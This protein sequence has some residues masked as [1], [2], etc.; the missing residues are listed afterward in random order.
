[1]KVTRL[2]GWADLRSR[3]I[4][5]SRAY[6]LRLEKAEKFPQRVR[7]GPNS[8]AWREDEIERWLQERSSART[9]PPTR[10]ASEAQIELKAS[11]GGAA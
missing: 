9:G 5:F 4:R 6:L 7:L 2:L 10:W 11:S 1:M 3:G 8:I